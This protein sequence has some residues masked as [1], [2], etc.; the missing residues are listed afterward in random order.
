VEPPFTGVA[1]KVTGF[2]EHIGLAEAVI[3]TETGWGVFTVMIIVFE[4]AGFGLGQDALDERMQDMRS[5]LTG[6]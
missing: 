2:P 3:L 6:V 4:L 5:P 1:V